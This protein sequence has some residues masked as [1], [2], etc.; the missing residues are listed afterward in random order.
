M[1]L[2]NKAKTLFEKITGKEYCPDGCE[3]NLDD[4]DRSTMMASCVMAS[5]IHELSESVNLVEVNDVGPAING[6]A[7]QVKR[8]ANKM[9]DEG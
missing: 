6:L 7:E 2:E 5:A 8:V 4:H 3:M 1:T 9:W